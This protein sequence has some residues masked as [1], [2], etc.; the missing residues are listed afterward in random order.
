MTYPILLLCWRRWKRLGDSF[1]RGL[2]RRCVYETEICV[3][4]NLCY[5]L[6]EV[7]G[8]R[9][10]SGRDPFA[11][12]HQE[13]KPLAVVV[14]IQRDVHRDDPHPRQHR[15]SL[16]GQVH[17]IGLSRLGSDGS[18]QHTGL[19]DDPGRCLQ[20]DTVPLR[21]IPEIANRDGRRGPALIGKV[22]AIRIG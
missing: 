11:E 9:N 12:P 6:P 8:Q 10:S 13:I 3:R 22:H 21:L 17:L 20:H 7:V 14:I 15:G 2:G 1:D 19:G 4:E 16:S 18:F 5:S